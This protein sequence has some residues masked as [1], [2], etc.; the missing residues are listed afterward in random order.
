MLKNS[1]IFFA[2]VVFVALLAVG[3]LFSPFWLNI[4]IAILLAVATSNINIVALR[5]TRN[6]TAAA[7][8][9][10]TFLGLLFAFPIAY[11]L[12]IVKNYATVFD[13]NNITLTIE[14]FKATD[15]HLPEALSFLEPKLKELI[16]NIDIKLISSKIISNLASIGKLSAHFLLDIGFI[17]VFF[18]FAMLYGTQLVEYTKNTLPMEAKDTQFILSEVAN[19]MSVVFYSVIANMIIQGTLFSFITMYYGYDGFLT[20]MIFGITSLVP[21]VGGLLAWAPISLYEFANGNAQAA[22]VI[23]AYSVV[24]ISFGADTLL[25]PL[26]IKFINDRLVKIPTKINELLIFFSMIA[27]ISTFGFWG[28]ILGPAIVTFFVSTIKLYTLLRDRSAF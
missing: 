4:L 21:V 7:I 1:Y 13:M 2:G 5:I 10:T 23:A 28:L 12:I 6:K 24:V 8:I 17:L 25:K 19:V 16:S 27:G 14:Y 15:F 20:G 9:T 11:S 22:L 18:F 26:V 3:Y